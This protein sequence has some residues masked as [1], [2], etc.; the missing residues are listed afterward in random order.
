V[1]DSR[2]RSATHA[3]LAH[4]LPLK[5]VRAHVSRPRCSGLR[6]A[7]AAISEASSRPSGTGPLPGSSTALAADVGLGIRPQT[8]PTD[9][10]CKSPAP[11]G[12]I[13]GNRNWTSPAQVGWNHVERLRRNFARPDLPVV[14]RVH[15]R[16]PASPHA[17]VR[18]PVLCAR[19]AKARAIFIAPLC[20]REQ[21]AQSRRRRATHR[22]PTLGQRGN[23]QTR[24]HPIVCGGAPTQPNCA[25]TPPNC[26]C[27]PA[28]RTSRA[29]ASRA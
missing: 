1:P 17:R 21:R 12:G 14:T 29:R 11:V 20:V 18:D 15:S 5:S 9:Q 27:P 6:A 25:L 28:R 2:S 3:R 26:R 4:D 23:E 13:F 8:N 22:T 7:S 19:P 24:A 10:A 16:Q